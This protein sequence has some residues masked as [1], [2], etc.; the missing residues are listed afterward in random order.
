MMQDKI[1]KTLSVLTIIAVIGY[2]T[3]QYM[4]TDNNPHLTKA[5]SGKMELYHAA[6]LAVKY[7]REYESFLN[8]RRWP[9][10]HF[11]MLKHCPTVNVDDPEE[12]SANKVRIAKTFFAGKGKEFGKPL[13]DWSS[14]NSKNFIVSQTE[15]IPAAAQSA[16]GFKDSKVPDSFASTEY[17]L[18]TIK[19]TS[20]DF[21]VANHILQYSEHALTLLNQLLRVIRYQGYVLFTVPNACYGNNRHRVVTD[22][23]HFQEEYAKRRRVVSNHEEHMLEWGLSQL[24]GM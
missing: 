1:S 19:S 12:A 23:H 7:E 21:V 8:G 24:Q 22:W 6:Q 4:T 10:S 13:L 3:F 2:M 16:F 9:G 20:L 5:Y 14:L 11:G 15:F 17:T 18:S